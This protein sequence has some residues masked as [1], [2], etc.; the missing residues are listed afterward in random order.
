[1]EPSSESAFLRRRLLMSVLRQRGLICAVGLVFACAGLLLGYTMGKYTVLVTVKKLAPNG[2]EQSASRRRT[3]SQEQTFREMMALMRSEQSLK[4]VATE[5]G[6]ALTSE[7][8]LSSSQILHSPGADFLTISVKGDSLPDA[9]RLASSHASS[10]TKFLS[11]LKSKSDRR[12][13][14]YYDQKLQEADKAF[15]SA[16]KDLITLQREESGAQWDNDLAEHIRHR[17]EQLKK[18]EDNK[19]RTDALDLQIKNLR[20]E[21][22]RHHP[23]FLSAKQE[24]DRALLRYTEDHP[25][26]QELKQTLVAIEARINQEKSE[27][28]PDISLNGSSLAQT[29]YAK[30]IELKAQAVT[31]E[32]EKTE[33]R[34]SIDKLGNSINTLPEEQ[35]KHTRLKSNYEFWKTLQEQINQ[36]RHEESVSDDDEAGSFEVFTPAESRASA[37][38]PKWQLGLLF[39]AGGGTFAMLAMTLGVCLQAMGDRRIRSEF[40]LQCATQLPVLAALGDVSKM[41]DEDKERWAFQTF[42]RLKAKLIAKGKE[43]FICG[44][45]SSGP[46]EGR[47]TWVNLLAHSAR[48]QGYRVLVVTTVPEAPKETGEPEVAE[49]VAQPESPLLPSQISRALVPANQQLTLQIALP[50]WVWNMENRSQWQQALEQLTNV[51]NL[52]VFVDLPPASEP[53]ALLLAHG[54]PNI[55]WLCGR[56]M[57]TSPETRSQLELLTCSQSGVAGAVFNLAAHR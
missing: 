57:A 44:F 43:A 5:S 6:L 27:V 42:T 35:I 30:L 1:M 53:E 14:S 16:S 23:A 32:Q 10:V 29:L 52:V 48:K 15:E 56:D 2:Q 51:A 17:D 37:W 49:S 28:D 19:K 9:F 4:Q 36:R 13:K 40:D 25:K 24:L 54:F 31:L 38:S 55:I 33:V 26:V 20:Q 50:G 11:D 7:E 21:V 45:T 39:G 22:A 34:A 41:S 46:G 8:V 18:L 12:V 47:S 3:K